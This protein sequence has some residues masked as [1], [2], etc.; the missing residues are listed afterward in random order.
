MTSAPA[1]IARRATSIPSASSG[2]FG[3]PAGSDDSG[4]LDWR[5]EEGQE[6]LDRAAQVH[7]VPTEGSPTSEFPQ[8]KTAD[9]V[10]STTSTLPA[11]RSLWIT[12][13][14]PSGQA[15]TSP[16]SRAAASSKIR[17]HSALARRNA[18]QPASR[19]FSSSSTMPSSASRQV[20]CL[21]LP[22]LGHYPNPVSVGGTA[23]RSAS[24]ASSNDGSAARKCGS[25]SPS[26]A[27]PSAHSEMA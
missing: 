8:S 17:D 3:E 25:G 22:W 1:S 9:T 19:G 6:S 24:T 10:P 15:S 4:R 5:V 2:V 16:A 20:S 13:R 11:V 23:A 21:A 14:T 18:R 26:M 12:W 27:S 7:L